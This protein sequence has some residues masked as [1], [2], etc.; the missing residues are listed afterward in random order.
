[1][2]KHSSSVASELM[3]QFHPD[4][5]IYDFERETVDNIDY[6]TIV[7]N[8]V[9][10]EAIISVAG[11]LSP[12][13]IEHNGGIYRNLTVKS[14][15]FLEQYSETPTKM[16]KE[17]YHN[18]LSVSQFL[19]CWIQEEKHTEERD[20]KDEELMVELAKIIE[21]FWN[22]KLKQD[23]PD[24]EFIFEISDGYVDNFYDEYG[25]CLTFYEK[26]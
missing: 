20:K 10:I 3:Y 7:G 21:Y 18:I 5:Q 22:M 1:M 19:G 17:K 23:F 9:P 16:L 6:F 14:A 2:N 8:L 24:R 11:L 12:D 4:Y 13:I 15:E 25:V 26:V